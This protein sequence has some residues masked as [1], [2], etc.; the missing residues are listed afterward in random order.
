MKLFHPEKATGFVP[1]VKVQAPVIPVP[2][3]AVSEP[4]V[5]LPVPQ[6]QTVQRQSQNGLH[7][8]VHDENFFVQKNIVEELSRQSKIAQKKGHSCIM[9]TGP[10]GSGKT[11]LANQEAALSKNVLCTMQ[12]GLMTEPTQWFGS[13]K[14]SPERGTYYVESQFVK[15]V[16]TPNA[17]ILFDEL[18]RVEN[19]KV[20]NSLFWLLDSRGEAYIDDLERTVKV[21]NGV[22]FFATLNEGTIF[23]G[24]DFMDTA[25]RDRFYVVPVDFPPANAEIEILV[26]K[27]GVNSDTASALVRMANTIRQDPRFERK[28][29]TRQLLMAT[30][31][32][33]AGASMLDAV[34]FAIANT[35]G[36]LATDIMIALQSHI[37]AEDA[38][39]RRD[40]EWV[41]F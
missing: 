5:T 22:V 20:H 7:I 8:P 36:E 1:P 23:A 31:D 9:F 33:V 34:E 28:V 17:R 29:S 30:E 25:L 18:N 10:A 40:A 24:I 14:F 38:R 37:P 11:S 15:A 27:T 41:K 32:I 4:V 19:P 12:C 2:K 39:R 6:A 3:P 13:Q 16:E 35:F 26:K 21:A